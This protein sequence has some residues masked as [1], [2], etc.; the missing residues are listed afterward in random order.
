[1]LGQ[2]KETTR[3]D[4]QGEE[5]GRGVCIEGSSNWLPSNLT[6]GDI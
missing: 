3:S 1:V 6:D 4:A 2:L 5:A